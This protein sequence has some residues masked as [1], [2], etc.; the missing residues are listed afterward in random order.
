MILD[1]LPRADDLARLAEQ[2]LPMPT[3]DRG[4][5]GRRA[6]SAT[7]AP[8]G[9]SVSYGRAFRAAAFLHNRLGISGPLARMTADRFE[10]LLRSG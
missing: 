7:A 2:L 4:A 10:L 3:A 5:R 8:R 9:R 1:Q 6:A